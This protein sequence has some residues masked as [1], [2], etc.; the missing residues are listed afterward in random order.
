MNAQHVMWPALEKREE[1]WQF[2]KCG[3]RRCSK[4]P[5]AKSIAKTLEKCYSSNLIA[6]ISLCRKLL[7]QLYP[8]IYRYGWNTGHIMA[9][10]LK[11]NWSRKF[12]PIGHHILLFSTFL[13]IF[14][15]TNFL[16]VT[17]EKLEFSVV[18]RK[19]KIFAI[20]HSDYG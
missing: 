18:R 7:R 3:K 15:I 11:H 8:R 2:V 20:F 12:C 13:A 19:L 17:V 1:A 6:N 4:L 14:L 10:T 9:L 5:F 16:L